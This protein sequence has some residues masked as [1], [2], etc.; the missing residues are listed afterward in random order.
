VPEEISTGA[1][2]VR[3]YGDIRI[4]RNY[5]RE[6]FGVFGD[7]IKKDAN[8]MALFLLQFIYGQQETYKRINEGN[9]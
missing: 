4:N 7:K 1:F 2:M 8:E 9:K 3:R 5:S 6:R